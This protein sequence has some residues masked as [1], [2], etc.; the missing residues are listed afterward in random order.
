MAPVG[1]GC[2]VH[3]LGLGAG[4]RGPAPGGFARRGADGAHGLPPSPPSGEEVFGSLEQPNKSCH[5]DKQGSVSLPV[6]RKAPSSS[7]CPGLLRCGVRHDNSLRREREEVWPP[8]FPGRTRSGGGYSG[9][10]FSATPIG[11][12]FCARPRGQ[13]CEDKAIHRKDGLSSCR[14]QRPRLL[15]GTAPQA[16]VPPR[17][18]QCRD[19]PGLGRG[20]AGGGEELSP[21]SSVTQGQ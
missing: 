19:E 6:P 12:G 21:R 14:P 16:P 1:D 20:G 11:S 13:S 8:G 15:G 17:G 10:L 5:F 2:P 18:P 9:K 4:G 7:D 3:G